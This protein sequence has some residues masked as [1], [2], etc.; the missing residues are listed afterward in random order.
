MNDRTDVAVLDQAPPAVVSQATSL[1]QAITAAASNPQTDIE[2]M[3][4]LF[5]MHQEMVKAEAEAAFNAALA[6]AQAKIIPI[7]TNAENA[8]TRSRYAKLEAINRQI[9]PIYTAE[10]LSVSF[11]S[12]ESPVQGW[13]RTEAT[14][15][16]RDG[17]SR[18]YHLDLP[19]DAEGAKGNLNKT[20]VQA[21]GSTNSYARRYLTNMIFNV[22]TFDDND[23]NRPRREEVMPDAEGKAR[24][25]AC[26][27]MDA[28]KKAWAGLTAKQRA[29]LNEVKNQCKTRIEEAD[30]AV[31]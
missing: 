13:Q 21:T 31:A 10:G 29:T 28:L 23:G 9:V 15:S 14:V 12:G 30:K 7:A 25:E 18:K 27:S 2:K 17:H 8:H 19:P 24:L 6:R 16:H 3:E 20:M 1:L 5:R 26:G 22:S 11:D 4:R